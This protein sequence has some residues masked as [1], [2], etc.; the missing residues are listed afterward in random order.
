MDRNSLAK[1]LWVENPSSKLPRCGC[2]VVDPRI[3]SIFPEPVSVP[4][5]HINYDV[6]IGDNLAKVQLTQTYL[7][8]LQNFLE[9]EYSFPMEPNACLY[10]FHA[11]F[12]DT[13]L[14]GRIKEKE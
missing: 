10:K 12:G 7:N 2:Y 9:V 5:K 13:L 4:L 6:Q 8:P 14:V 3:R 1:L 11:K